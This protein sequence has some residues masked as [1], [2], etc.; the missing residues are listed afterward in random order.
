MSS[1]S[2]PWYQNSVV[3]EMFLL[4]FFLV[5]MVVEFLHNTH[6]HVLCFWGLIALVLTTNL[7]WMILKCVS[8]NFSLPRD[9]GSLNLFT[10]V[11]SF[12]FHC[13]DI[14]F[15][16]MKLAVMYNMFKKNWFCSFIEHLNYAT[17][18]SVKCNL[19]W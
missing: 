7:I 11:V 5:R 9:S 2:W 17:Y 16:F 12:P 13:E 6:L 19:G 18:K 8:H 1:S 15:F 10:A 14:K 4:S 3:I